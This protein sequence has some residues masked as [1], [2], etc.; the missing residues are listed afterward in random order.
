[1]KEAVDGCWSLVV[2]EQE[3][4]ALLR[5]RVEAAEA[6]DVL[7]ATQVGLEELERVKMQAEV[8]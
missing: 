6:S 7:L 1:M 4:S 3:G 5:G 2:V 8:E